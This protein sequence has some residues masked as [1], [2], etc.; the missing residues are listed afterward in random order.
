M[1]AAYKVVA[2]FDA[3]RTTSQI[4]P[5]PAGSTVERRFSAA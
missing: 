3:H 2:E 5:L 1:I 4:Q